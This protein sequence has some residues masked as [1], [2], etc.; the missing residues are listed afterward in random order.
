VRAGHSFRLIVAA[1]RYELTSTTPCAVTTV[2]VIHAGQTT[3][4]N[5]V[6]TDCGP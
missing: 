6:V 4:H 2:V 5:I 1:G 3:H